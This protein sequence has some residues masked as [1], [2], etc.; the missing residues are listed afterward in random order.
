MK[1]KL[2]LGIFLI[3]ISI[4]SCSTE[5]EETTDTSKE[6]EQELALEYD[7]V[8]KIES[9][10]YIFKKTGETAKF[11]NEDRDFNF[12][13]V[14]ELLY[15]ATT[16][17]KHAIEG[18]TVTNPETKEFMVFSNLEESK[19]GFIRFDLEF[20]TGQTLSSVMYKP[21]KSIASSGKWHGEPMLDEPSPVIGAMIEFSQQELVKEC[22]A[23]L[24]V[25]TNTN[26]VPTVTLIN[27]KGWFTEIEACSLVCH[28]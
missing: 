15:N 23:V 25:C 7:G 24:E 13:F 19:S 6:L 17:N 26:G 5:S 4:Q 27:G 21:G 10:T 2:L 9:T 16:T 1:K 22:R 8:L 12:K 28:D 11:L 18:L 3:S 20:S 14:N